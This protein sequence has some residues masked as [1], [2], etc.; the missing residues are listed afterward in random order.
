[1]LSVGFVTAATSTHSQLLSADVISNRAKGTVLQLNETRE[2]MNRWVVNC[3]N[4]INKIYI[5]NRINYSTLKNES[6]DGRAK[7]T[8]VFARRLHLQIYCS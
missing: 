6:A 5:I 3:I 8:I 7:L 4:K 1:M 2:T